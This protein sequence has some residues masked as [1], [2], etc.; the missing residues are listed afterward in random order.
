MVWQKSWT[1]LHNLKRCKTSSA[2][3]V[4]FCQED[5][6]TI[7]L[8]FEVNYRGFREIN[9]PT[10]GC[11]VKGSYSNGGWEGGGG[12]GGNFHVCAVL[13]R[14]CTVTTT[15]PSFHCRSACTYIPRVCRCSVTDCLNLALQMC[16]ARPFKWFLCCAVFWLTYTIYTRGIMPY[17]GGL[18]RQVNSFRQG[19]L[20]GGRAEDLGALP[21]GH[22]AYVASQAWRKRSAKART[23]GWVRQNVTARKETIY[24]TGICPIFL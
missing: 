8:R 19:T 18:G 4:S 1:V 13:S 12:G 16:N 17:C 2:V 10:S 3:L 6:V 7:L 5:N 20:A 14:V 21:A 24:I 23:G 22:P 15:E 11:G 9:T